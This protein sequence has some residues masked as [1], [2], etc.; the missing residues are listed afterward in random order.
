MSQLLHFPPADKIEPVCNIATP[1]VLML[2][3]VGM[4]PDIYYQERVA[5]I[6]KR[7]VLVGVC[8][9]V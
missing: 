5:T 6:G 1:H 9:W 4:F 3:V 7:R 2:E 8:G